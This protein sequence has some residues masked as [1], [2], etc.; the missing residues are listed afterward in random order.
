M[1]ETSL[2]LTER[3]GRQWLLDGMKKK[4]MVEIGKLKCEELSHYVYLT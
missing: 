2:D 4:V 3:R 1:V